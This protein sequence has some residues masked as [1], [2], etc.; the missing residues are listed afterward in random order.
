MNNN[1]FSPEEI[2]RK[3]LISAL[4]LWL[5]AEF[6]AFAVFPATEI[7]KPAKGELNQW[8]LTSL[9]LGLG[10]VLLFAVTSRFI[11]L[12]H[13]RENGSGKDVIVLLNQV[14]G[15]L[16]MLGVIYPMIVTVQKFFS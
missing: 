13:G 14:G 15:F 7:I 6:I 1:N 3:D 11:T 4:T 8:F 12:A 16:A 10:G 9:P 5:L 2:Q